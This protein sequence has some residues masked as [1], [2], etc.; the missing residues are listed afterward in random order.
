MRTKI[1]HTTLTCLLEYLFPVGILNSI[2]YSP[3]YAFLQTLK[4][5]SSKTGIDLN[6]F[7]LLIYRSHIC[8]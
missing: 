7:I 4:S 8:L 1:E 6:V 3:P 2:K 5:Y